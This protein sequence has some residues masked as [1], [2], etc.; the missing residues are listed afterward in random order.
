MYKRPQFAALFDRIREPRRFI[1]VL[2]GPRQCGKTTLINQ[3]LR[4][5]PIPSKYASADAPEAHVPAWLDQQWN[6]ARLEMAAA[7]RRDFVL[8]LDEIQKTPAWSETVKKL[9]DEDTRGG[10]GLKVVLLG[11]SSLLLQR[12]LSESMTGRFEILR[13]GHWT[14]SEMREAFG[15]D[16]DPYIYFG[17]SGQGKVV[18]PKT[19]S[20]EYGPD[21]R[22][23]YGGFQG[24]PCGPG[25]L[26]QVGGVRGRRSFAGVG[27]RAGDPREL[28]A[29]EPEGIGFCPGERG[30]AGR[31]RSQERTGARRS[32]R[33]QFFS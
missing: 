6:A 8:V 15:F 16:L 26:G 2:S 27:S 3:V 28:L 33:D 19:P 20:V 32:S 5:L 25:G 10:L 9:W 12:G 7:P 30:P 13:L 29:R 24:S 23:V 22:N 17:G 1:Q 11:S 31:D 18:E 4:E 14:Y 21:E